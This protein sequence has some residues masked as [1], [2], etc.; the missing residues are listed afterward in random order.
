MAAPL[1]SSL[2]RSKD[3]D[4]KFEKIILVHGKEDALTTTLM[5]GSYFGT[6]ELWARDWISRLLLKLATSNLH[7]RNPILVLLPTRS[8]FS[9]KKLF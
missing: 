4:K 7:F 5:I 2:Q 6:F 1:L 9:D 8:K 3:D